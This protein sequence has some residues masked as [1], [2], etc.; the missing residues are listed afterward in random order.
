MT[1][2]YTPP[3]D[4]LAGTPRYTTVAAVKAA[5]GI[6]SAKY[7]S[8]I[9]ASIVTI[10]YLVDAHLE[11]SFPQDADPNAGTDDALNPPP[12]EGIPPAV[13]Q[14]SLVGAIK[15]FKLTDTPF[16]VGGS[17]EFI[18]TID[19]GNETRRAFNSVKPLLLGLQRAWGAA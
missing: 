7:D 4:P 11:T 12:I 18:G 10:E 3:P 2:D 8:E 16:G 17:D 15:V 1:N 6:D 13:I 9:T 5:I 19:I 14:A